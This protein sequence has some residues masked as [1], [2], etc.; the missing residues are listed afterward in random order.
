MISEEVSEEALLE[1]AETGDFRSM[2]EACKTLVLEGITTAG[3]ALRAI[4]STAD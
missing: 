3:E 4:N 1:E 2:K